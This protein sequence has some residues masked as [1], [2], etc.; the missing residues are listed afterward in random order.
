MDVP[1]SPPS[2]SCRPSCTF[3]ESK[4]GLAAVCPAPPE[5]VSVIS[6]VVS[7]A[8]PSSCPFA[9]ATSVESVTAPSV[10]PFAAPH[11]SRPVA[12]R[13]CQVAAPPVASSFPSVRPVVDSPFRLSSMQF[14]CFAFSVLSS[15]FRFGSFRGFAPCVGSLSVWLR[16]FVFAYALLILDCIVFFVVCSDGIWVANSPCGMSLLTG[17]PLGF[18][19]RCCP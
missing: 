5:S 9:S 16:S 13:F 3:A 12:T 15:V 8:Q 14:R 2:Q 17:A 10:R 7:P 18:T 1:G 4:S 11:L 6:P 19:F